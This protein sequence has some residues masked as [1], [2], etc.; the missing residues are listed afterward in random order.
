MELF[1]LPHTTKVQKVIAK[2]AFDTYTNSKQKLMFTDK[3]VRITWLHKLSPRTVNLEAKEVQ[4]I[5][6]FKIELKIK[7]EIKPILEIIDKAMPYHIIFI[8]EYNEEIYLSTSSKHP[9]PINPDNSV[10][11]WTFKTD[12]FLPDE[13]RYTLQLKKS[14]DWVF[15][16]FCN[17]LSEKPNDVSMAL[18]DL[19][20]YSKKQGSLKKEIE[21]LKTKIKN[22]NQFNIKVELNLL[23]KQKIKELE[24]L[25]E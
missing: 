22:C 11:D 24:R 10:I 9:Y 15:N 19:V 25:N 12:W 3:I 1:I 6:I 23:L 16:D 8:V 2:N 18:E 21:Q 14:L 13:N 5:Q 20:Q 7:E 17:Q 4:E